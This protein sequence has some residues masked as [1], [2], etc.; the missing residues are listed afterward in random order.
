MLIL[1]VFQ[2]RKSK[3]LLSVHPL[4]FDPEEYFPH[5]RRPSAQVRA[6]LESHMKGT[7]HLHRVAELWF[8][9]TKQLNFK[10]RDDS[11]FF[12]GAEKLYFYLDT[13]TGRKTDKT[14]N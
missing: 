12:I 7:D 10:Y 11:K 4:D 3:R 5:S 1:V 14:R 2:M 8:I 13:K 6:H 9:E